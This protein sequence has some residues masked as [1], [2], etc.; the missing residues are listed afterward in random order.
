MDIEFA[1]TI[2]YRSRFHRFTSAFSLGESFQIGRAEEA[3]EFACHEGND[4]PPA[5]MWRSLSLHFR[6]FELCGHVRLHWQQQGQAINQNKEGIELRR[7]SGSVI[8]VGIAGEL[9]DAALT[10]F[11]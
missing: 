6:R 11:L 4:H 1:R 5:A 9:S 8:S 3:C 7:A 2:P 10:Q